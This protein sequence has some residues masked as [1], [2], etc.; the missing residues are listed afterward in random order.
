MVHHYQRL[1]WSLI[2]GNHARMAFSD[3]VIIS[4]WKR[5]R[6]RCECKAENHSHAGRCGA[7]LIWN[8][9][10]ATGYSGWRACKKAAWA[11]DVLNACEITCAK[12]QGPLTGG[13]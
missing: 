10:G 4:A 13:G 2:I 7:R 11:T 1:Y 6:G 3:D 5:S 8:L 12:W 9:Q